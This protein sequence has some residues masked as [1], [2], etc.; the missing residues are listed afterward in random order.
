M[1]SVGGI[2]E[3]KAKALLILQEN[4][5]LLISYIFLILIIVVGAVLY[6]NP[7]IIGRFRKRRS[8]DKGDKN[9]KPAREDRVA[10][11]EM[12]KQILLKLDDMETKNTKVY[13]WLRD[14]TLRS[15]VNTIYM[16]ELPI[17]YKLDA[18]IV[19]A[20]LKGNGNVKKK[21][22]KVIN[23]ETTGKEAWEKA[24]HDDIQKNG[25]CTEQFFIDTI[26]WIDERLM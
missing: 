16:P 5:I 22:V 21:M 8:Y 9:D 26:K 12:I 4:P 3:A 15:C 6:K 18:F 13:F 19:Y 17:G 14:D 11:A 25:M 7:G 23:S 1:E 2:F 10:L 20:K 24:K